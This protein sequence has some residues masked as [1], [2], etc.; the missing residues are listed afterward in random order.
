MFQSK[1]KSPFD[2][3]QVILRE[4]KNQSQSP[5]SPPQGEKRS[6]RT[7]ASQIEAEA[8]PEEHSFFSPLLAER[9]FGIR[10]AETRLWTVGSMR[11]DFSTSMPTVSAVGDYHIPS[12]FNAEIQ[13]LCKIACSENQTA[14][15]LY[16]AQWLATLQ[17][18]HQDRQRQAAECGSRIEIL[19][20]GLTKLRIVSLNICLNYGVFDTR[21]QLVSGHFEFRNNRLAEALRDQ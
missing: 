3:S 10:A 18:A 8:R 7:L 6:R 9:L 19:N 2:L 15:K 20:S 12:A 1:K 13:S 11:I 5:Q 16:L 4:K 14:P 17:D 21:P